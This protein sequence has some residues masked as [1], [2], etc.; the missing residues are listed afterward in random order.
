MAAWH[1]RRALASKA[2]AANNKTTKCANASLPK[3]KV[4]TIVKEPSQRLSPPSAHTP[5]DKKVLH[6]EHALTIISKRQDQAAQLHPITLNI[7]S[8]RARVPPCDN[9]CDMTIPLVLWCCLSHR[10]A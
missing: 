7:S 2:D 10:N 3:E 1:S 6:G 8:R 9:P 4:A 5:K